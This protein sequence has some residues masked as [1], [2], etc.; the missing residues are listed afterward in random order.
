MP[1]V[2]K[3]N[4]GSFLLGIWEIAESLDT[5]VNA[6][7]FYLYPSEK[8]YLR[9]ISSEK[10]KKQWLATRLLLKHLLGSYSLIFYDKYGRPYLENKSISISH[11]GSYV[12]LMI[13]NK[14]CAIDIEKISSRVEKLKTKFLSA[15][16]QNFCI[17]DKICTLLWSLKETA[18]KYYGR[19]GLSFVKNIG[20]KKLDDNSAELVIKN[21]NLLLSLQISITFFNGYV[22]T[23][24]SQ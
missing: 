9:S 16:E 21:R 4:T 15:S 12:A 1:V 22:L 14:R 2:K 10:R 5:L 19:K 23:Y 18:Y 8:E 20:I 11:S 6:I 3:I 13:A 7:A 17:D 24:C